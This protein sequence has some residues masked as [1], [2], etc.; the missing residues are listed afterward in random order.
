MDVNEMETMYVGMNGLSSVFASFFWQDELSIVVATWHMNEMI[1]GELI[2]YYGKDNTSK[3]ILIVHQS[4]PEDEIWKAMSSLKLIIVNGTSKEM[5]LLDSIYSGVVHTEEDAP[6]AQLYQLNSS[7]E[8]EL[9]LKLIPVLKT[10]FM[11]TG[12][13][14]LLLQHLEFSKWNATLFI[15]VLKDLNVEWGSAIRVMKPLMSCLE[16]KNDL[17]YIELKCHEAN[18]IQN[19]KKDTSKDHMYL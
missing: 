10:P 2:S 1:M 15:I 19:K 16:T 14:A 12:M 6:V 5:I 17:L 3:I 11:V 9:K 18:C 4:I 7:C 8:P 13:S